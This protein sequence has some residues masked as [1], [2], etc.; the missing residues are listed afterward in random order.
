MDYKKIYNNLVLRAKNRLTE[1]YTETHH[2]VPR[3]MGGSDDSDNLVRLTPEEHYVAHQLLVKMYQSNHALVR[4]A[5]MMIPNRPSNKLYG[6]LR[7]KFAEAQSESQQ[8]ERNSQYGTRWVNDGATEKKIG[9]L[10]K[11][12]NDFFSGRLKKKKEPKKCKLCG[13]LVCRDKKMCSRHQM[14]NTFI[15]YLDFDCNVI[16]SLKFYDEFNRIVDLLKYDYNT[17]LS[18]E[19]IRSKYNLTSNE[20]VR[21]MFKSLGIERRTLSEAVS[22]Y[23][24]KSHKH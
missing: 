3:C 6:W 1:G 4:A 15:R 11:I 24:K 13:Q 19:D 22:N 14:V 18:I 12:P 2:I 20:R 9:K 7:R 16:G 23:S 5:Q 21:M 8:G 17:G 10:E